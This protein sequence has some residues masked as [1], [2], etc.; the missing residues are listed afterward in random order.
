METPMEAKHVATYHVIEKETN[1]AIH[2]WKSHE[3]PAVSYILNGVW[4][5]TSIT[6]PKYG[7]HCERVQNSSIIPFYT[8][9]FILRS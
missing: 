9:W 8:G 3:T 5:P 1:G 4:T 6:Q 2:F 7:F